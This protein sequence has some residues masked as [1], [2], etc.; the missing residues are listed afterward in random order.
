MREAHGGGL[1]GHFGEKKTCE[2]LKEHFVLPSMLRDVH[3][4]IERCAICKTSKGKENAYG[5]Y[6]SLPI[7]EQPWM[8]FSMEF[9]L[10][11]PRTQYGKDSIMFVVDR[12]SK[13]SHFIPCNKTNDAVH[14]ADLF[15]Q[16]IVR[17]HGVPKSIDSLE[18]AWNEITYQYDMSSIN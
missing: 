1:S 6:M 17:L 7:P 5:L 18:E 14:V 2:V 4:V 12:F 9:V 10:G 8:N 15:F 16:E 11:L 3:K 13:M